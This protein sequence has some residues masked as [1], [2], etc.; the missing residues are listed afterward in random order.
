MGQSLSAHASSKL[1][2][3]ILRSD[4][5]DCHRSADSNNLSN[6]TKRGSTLDQEISFE[7]CDLE[8]SVIR[9]TDL[10]ADQH[11]QFIG[12]DEVVEDDY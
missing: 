5:I 11:Y 6:L 7:E 2:M 1:S 10:E 12:N 9:R 4:S 3:A 8:L